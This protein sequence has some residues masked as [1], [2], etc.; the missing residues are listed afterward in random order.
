MKI[1]NLALHQVLTEKGFTHFHHANTVATAMTFFESHGILSRGQVERRGLIQTKQASDQEDK[2][3][4]VWDDVFIDILDLHGFFPR[5]N[6][7]GPVL[8]KFNI[9]FLLNDDLDVWV[10]KNNPIYWSSQTT[11]EEKY[12]Q[13]IDEIER[14]WAMYPIQ[15]R[16][17]TIRKP[18]SPLLFDYL[19]EIVIDNPGVQI[20]NDVV[21]F[22]EAY[23]AIEGSMDGSTRN[24]LK[25]RSCSNCF[26][27][28]NYLR[29]IPVGELAKLFLPFNHPRFSIG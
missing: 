4:D 1:P 11:Q 29:Q 5:Q 27:H 17:F 16:M 14:T 25:V 23:Q 15:Q 10:T 18:T 13:D 26:C 19:D 8:F 20:Y 24:K 28:E 12:F 9:D 3:Y 21:L 6:I 7:Y 22:S 2:D